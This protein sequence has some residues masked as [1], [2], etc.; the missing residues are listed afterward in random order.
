MWWRVAKSSLIPIDS[1]LE[2]IQDFPYT[3]TY[4]I[5]R[6]MQIDSFDELPKNDRPPESIWDDAEALED[7]FD[8]LRSPDR[9]TGIM[10]DMEDIEG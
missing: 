4:V 10:I 8:A 3:L 1:G 9:D 6:R 7:W 5:M 2:D